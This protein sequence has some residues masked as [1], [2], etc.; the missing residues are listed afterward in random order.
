MK[1]QLSYLLLAIVAQLALNVNG[2]CWKTLYGRGAG[3]AALVCRTGYVRENGFCYR[4]CKSG[5]TG[6]GPVC[7]WTSCQGTMATSCG[8]L[9]A[10]NATQCAS[11]KAKI[12]YESLDD[13]VA[14]FELYQANKIGQAQAFINWGFS[15]LTQSLTKLE[16]EK[17][18][19]TPGLY[20][21]PTSQTLVYLAVN[22]VLAIQL[23][24][25][26]N[27]FVFFDHFLLIYF[28]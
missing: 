8:A 15:N 20:V 28:I 4:P 6:Y 25:D 11:I 3:E 21:A 18:Y 12:E 5:Y 14:S 23:M 9:C 13:A 19:S 7:A 16:L 1:S 17:A 26:G 2:E 22:E 10:E 24:F 27:L